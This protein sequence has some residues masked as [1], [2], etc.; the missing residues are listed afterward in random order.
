MIW[1]RV[2]ALATG[3]SLPLLLIL[4]RV[5]LFCNSGDVT[6]SRLRVVV[7]ALELHP[8]TILIVSITDPFCVVLS[9]RMVELSILLMTSML[10]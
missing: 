6:S 2:L 3:V 4:S 7:A 10:L 8:S 9:A 5:I 1:M